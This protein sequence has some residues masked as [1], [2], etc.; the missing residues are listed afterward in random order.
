VLGTAWSARSES[1]TRQAEFGAF[2]LGKIIH[3][4]GSIGNLALCDAI[5]AA[6]EAGWHKIQIIKAVRH[7]TGAGLKE[8]RDYVVKTY[9]FYWK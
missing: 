7:S 8:A 9:G 6:H 3:D 2:A 5:S 1:E 4:D